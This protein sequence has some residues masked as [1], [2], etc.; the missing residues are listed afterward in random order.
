MTL[1]DKFKQEPKFTQAFIKDNS[2][3]EHLNDVLKTNI[4]KPIIEH[5]TNEYAEKRIDVLCKIDEGE[6]LIENQYGEADFDHFGK[7]VGHLYQ[8]SNYRYA[9]WIA[10]SFNDIF[11]RN[12]VTGFNKDRKDKKIILVKASII[13]VNNED[14]VIFNVENPKDIYQ[15]Q[16]ASNT[17]KRVENKNSLIDYVIS[18][19]RSNKNILNIIDDFGKNKTIRNFIYFH[20]IAPKTSINVAFPHGLAQVGLGTSKDSELRHKF[21]DI[22]EDIKSSIND[23]G[24]DID[25][26]DE[27]KNYVGVRIRRKT[28][29]NSP[30]ENLQFA[31]KMIMKSMEIF[32]KHIS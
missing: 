16:S 30:E 29:F 20:R 22:F 3:L 9:I 24:L 7:V 4:R 31:E 23:D 8:K 10:E 26:T 27:T 32:R 25:L 2:I 19:L 12:A 18:N 5:K 15:I 1:Q 11:F 28:Q 21:N 17:V 13:R 14:K 6:V